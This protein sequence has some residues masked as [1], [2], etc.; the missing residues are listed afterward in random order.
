MN[1][2]LGDIRDF[3]LVERVVREAAPEIVLHLAA[4]S[5]VR[6]SYR[7]PVETYQTNVMGTVHLL[8]A[9]RS[10]PSV[11]AVINVTSD[12]SYENREWVWPYREQDRL[13]GHDPYSNSKACAELVTSAFRSSF[14]PSESFAIHRVAIATARAGNVIGGGDWAADRLVPDIMRAIAAGEVVNIRSPQAIRPWQH[15]LEPLAGYLLLAE[16]LYDQGDAFAE[17]WNFGPSDND[18]RPVSWIVDYLTSKWKPAGNWAIDPAQQP[19]EAH[20]LKL[21][22]SKARERLNWAPRWQL[23][24]ALERILSWQQAFIDGQDMRASSLRDIS[25]YLQG[26]N[27]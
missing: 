20:Y 13:G 16:Q 18:A 6:Y 12:K 19:H 26:T 9:I 24:Q 1:S 7:H 3:N 2:I 10:T 8:E 22:S 17:A 5:L 15:V 23:E 27:R 14:F 11:R 25:D 4:Q 21:D